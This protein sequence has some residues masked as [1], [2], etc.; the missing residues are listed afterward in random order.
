VITRKDVL[1]A[2]ESA[3]QLPP[4]PDVVIRV[5][6]ELS[7]PDASINKLVGLL[8]QDMTLVAQLI[9]VANSAFHASKS[10]ITTVREAALRL[11][12]RE[13]RRIVY[14]A[15]FVGRYRNTGGARSERFWCHSLAVAMASRAVCKFCKQPISPE[16]H[17]AAYVAGL[18]HDLGA[19]A[20]LHWFEAECAETV[21]ATREQGGTTSECEFARWGIDHAEVGG[22]LAKRW[23]LPRLIQQGIRYHHQP[24]LA[25]PA[26]RTVV[27]LV[28]IADFVCSNQGFS[29]DETGL[30]NWFD[31]DAWDSLGLSLDDSQ[32]IIDEVRTDGEN[33]VVLAK[34]LTS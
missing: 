23:Q 3:D 21:V 14:T 18:L 34:A 5:E 15:A 7:R 24:W 11:G 10:R 13:L 2:L 17:E 26:D 31:S 16:A 1:T 19:L 25:D 12:M 28:H 27:R 29:R 8:E 32:S 33:S 22:L 20:L 4:F 9:R 30:P 6:K